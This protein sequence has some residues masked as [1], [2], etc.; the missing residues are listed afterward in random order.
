MT[1][2]K[3]EPRPEGGEN[4]LIDADT[5][6]SAQSALFDLSESEEMSGRMIS[7]RL[8]FCVN[9]RWLI[10]ATVRP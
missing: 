10:L 6:E 9:G 1:A 4:I 7:G 8:P 5:M 2:I 3:R